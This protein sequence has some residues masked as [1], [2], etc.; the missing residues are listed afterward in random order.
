[1]EVSVRG[2]TT[3]PHLTSGQPKNGLGSLIPEFNCNLIKAFQFSFESD[4]NKDVRGENTKTNYGMDTTGEKERRTP[5]EN[6]DGRSTSSHDNKK[7]RTRSMEKQR[8]MAIGCRK[9]AT[10]VKNTG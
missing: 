1:M 3:S 4:K 7:F 5:K 6:V 2:F 8:G 10:A 9:T